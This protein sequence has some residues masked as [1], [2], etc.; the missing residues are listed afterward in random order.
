[1]KYQ[2]VF[3]FIYFG[4]IDN[5]SMTK[6]PTINVD[7]LNRTLNQ[8]GDDYKSHE[9]LYKHAA[10]MSADL[11]HR[12]LLEDVRHYKETRPWI[13][14]IDYMSLVV[15]EKDG[16]KDLKS[17]QIQRSTDVDCV[18]LIHETYIAKCELIEIANHQYDEFKAI[19]SLKELVRVDSDKYPEFYNLFE[20]YIKFFDHEIE[21]NSLYILDNFN[22]PDLTLHNR[23]LAINLI[24]NLSSFKKIHLE[25]MG[26]N[27][28]VKGL[29]EFF[30]HVVAGSI[31]TPNLLPALQ[32]FI[33]L[34]LFPI[35][36]KNENVLASRRQYIEW[37]VNEVHEECQN[38]RILRYQKRIKTLADKHG[39]KLTNYIAKNICIKFSEKNWF[40][41]M[42]DS[43][44]KSGQHYDFVITAL[45]LLPAKT[46]FRAVLNKATSYMSTKK[47]R[48]ATS[49]SKSTVKL[50]IDLDEKLKKTIGDIC[51]KEEASIREFVTEAILNELEGYYPEEFD[52]Y[53]DGDKVTRRPPSASAL[54]RGAAYKKTKGNDHLQ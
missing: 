12:Y 15:A 45:S 23:L 24:E 10:L 34:L 27:V 50:N 22:H 5:E 39:E 51:K 29:T 35:L 48:D 6:N 52:A 8:L 25:E 4:F 46:N 2:R 18:C 19:L 36:F 28:K 13:L 38:I 16:N 21:K 49:D 54:R 31:L 1:M 26:M 33:D 40:R 11:L 42:Q 44:I 32:A 53:I 37:V 41:K 30:C 14:P 7:K 47:H 3:N 43:A 17:H 20:L 9:G